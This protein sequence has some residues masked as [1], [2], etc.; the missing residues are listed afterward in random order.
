MAFIIPLP[1][2]QGS[3]IAFTDVA[4]E[5][6]RTKWI[7]LTDEQIVSRVH[8]AAMAD[9]H[10]ADV[11]KGH[12]IDWIRRYIYGELCELVG[13][14]ARDKYVANINNKSEAERH[15]YWKLRRNRDEHALTLM[16]YTIT[17]QILHWVIKNDVMLTHLFRA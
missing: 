10:F 5:Y 15:K 8:K 11:I 14:E 6:V 4:Y 13:N 3:F 17:L 9:P 12:N 2:D 7:A 16:P 1:N